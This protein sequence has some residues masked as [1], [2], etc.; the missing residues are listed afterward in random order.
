MTC[1]ARR[2]RT[3]LRAFAGGRGHAVHDGSHE[4]RGYGGAGGSGVL[5]QVQSVGRTHR[6]EL[7]VFVDGEALAD[8]VPP[9][10][11]RNLSAVADESEFGRVSVTWNAPPGRRR[12]GGAD[13]AVGVPGVPVP[14]DDGLVRAGGDGGGARVCGHGPGGVDDVLLHGFGGGRFGQRVGPRGPGAGEDAGGGPGVSGSTAQRV[15]G[16]GGGIHGPYH[17]ALERSD[18]G[19]GRGGADGS[20]G[21]HGVPVG[22]GSGLAGGGGVVGRGGPGVRGRGLALSD[23]VWVCGVGVRRRRQRVGAVVGVA[24]AH[25]GDRGSVRGACPGRNRSH[26]GELGGGGRRGVAGV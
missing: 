13:G 20:V 17:G 24:R 8:E 1:I 15:G 5:L 6:S 4:L 23:G 19:R 22:R 14:G 21:I 9:E 16:C 25:G 26:R 2:V 3:G 10:S 11:P 18:D 12:R 7:S